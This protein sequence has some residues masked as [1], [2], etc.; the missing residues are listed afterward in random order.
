MNVRRAVFVSSSVALAL[1]CGGAQ[2]PPP[3]V[4]AQVVTAPPPPPPAPELTAVDEPAQ[5]VFFGRVARPADVLKIAGGWTRLPMPGSDVAAEMLTGERTG[6]IV[7]LEQPVD[8]VV[9]ID[10]ARQSLSPA[11]AVGAAVLSL[12][13]AKA[14]LSKHHKL[15]PGENGALVV[16]SLGGGDSD[17]DEDH[18]RVCELAPSVGASTT[19]LV[20]GSSESAVRQ[21]APFLT[22]TAPRT[23]V[24]SDVHI[25][26]RLEPLKSFVALGRTMMPGLLSE[27]MGMRHGADP[28]A[29]DLVEALTGEVADLATDL[30][31][32]TVDAKLEDALGRV[33][34]RVT[35]KTAS[36]VTA[37]L[38]TEHPDRVDLPPA[39]FWHLPVDSDAAY[40]NRGIDTKE[41]DHPRELLLKLLNH[42]LEKEGLG[43]AD[44]KALADGLTHLVST[45]APTVFAKG[46]D[47]AA[48][49]QA[50]DAL[51]AAKDDPAQHE[52]ATRA[53]IDATVG[54]LL[55]G[56]D[57]SPARLE[58][59]LKEL[60]SA[61][62]RPA[63]AKL[64]KV[65]ASGG[66]PPSL[67][68]VP[69]APSLKLP[70]G[71][72]HLELTVFPPHEPPH[73]AP[74]GAAHGP[75]AKPEPPAKP[76]KLHAFAVPDAERVWL[77]V[78]LDEA[79]IAAKVRASLAS[80]PADGTLTARAGLESMKDA[81]ASSGG[82]TTIR[83]T[84][85]THPDAF[86][87][88][89]GAKARRVYA[90]IAQLPDQGATPIPFLTTAAPG[91]ADSPAGS[92][93]STVR[94]PKPA[95]EGIVKVAI[96]GG[97]F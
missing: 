75:K 60:A 8:V 46:V 91:S 9:A 85:T 54:W 79:A 36:S 77:V 95:I 70:K 58:G 81:R 50:L 34:S 44:R 33:D 23:P 89:Q 71:T 5:M 35:F 45:S 87:S 64:M 92:L 88:T 1:A 69:S 67:K 57:E 4:T 90:T 2:P 39:S 49:R 80:A 21:L 82:F 83:A 76:F 10:A 63:L 74:P 12:D 43:D 29:R 18:P 25:E 19:R 65:A 7:D 40:F 14:A 16:E 73:P 37:R 94:V 47:I 66:T 59:A 38:A 3:P 86:P 56:Y 51:Q 20:C 26:V 24:P 48:V 61:W 41:L 11:W 55:V 68:I 93:S 28:A 32:I 78:G 22:R 62:N 42:A 6:K 31:R 17:A 96:M 97:R 30:S 15:V 27:A 52:A 13:D 72:T 53:A 84:L